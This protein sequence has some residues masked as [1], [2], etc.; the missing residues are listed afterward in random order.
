MVGIFDMSCGLMMDRYGQE[1]RTGGN[2][3]PAASPGWKLASTLPSGMLVEQWLSGWHPDCKPV[4][5]LLPQ[6]PRLAEAK[7]LGSLQLSRIQQSFQVIL[8][9]SAV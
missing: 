1:D 8:I 9:H 3:K 6:L 7:R 4:V 5:S 2:I